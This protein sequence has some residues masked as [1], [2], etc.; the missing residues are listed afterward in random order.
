MDIAEADIQERIKTPLG[1][2]LVFLEG[3]AKVWLSQWGSIN[4]S[5]GSLFS[6]VTS[7]RDNEPR[8]WSQLIHSSRCLGP[9]I[10]WPGSSTSNS[11]VSFMALNSPL[12]Q[13]EVGNTLFLLHCW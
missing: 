10:K 12:I 3:I 2:D 7:S 4:P 6:W 8:L 13:S 1:G 11:S 5:C 9:D